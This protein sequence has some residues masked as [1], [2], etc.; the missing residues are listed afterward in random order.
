MQHPA[1]ERSAQTAPGPRAWPLI[2]DPAA[3]RGPRHLLQY[4]DGCWRRYGD[5]FRVNVAGN[6]MLVVAHPDSIKD[7]L[8]T[9][10]HN[11]V[12]GSVYQ[13]VR[14]ILG[15]GLLTLE[16]D[17]WK[18]RRQLAQPTFHRRSLEKLA[19]IMRE[20]GAARLADLQRRAQSGPVQIDAHHEMVR[21]TLDVVVSALFGQ[22]LDVGTVTYEAL[23]SAL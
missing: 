10:R 20:R 19:V 3:L 23:G 14:R 17:A 4:L 13:N 11:Y 8:W 9:K 15:D 18:T 2:G 16:G 1:S 5:T 22:A 12:K 7:V 6:R 21:L